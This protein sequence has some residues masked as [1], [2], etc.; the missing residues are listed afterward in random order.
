MKG[1][2]LLVSGIWAGV[3]PARLSGKPSPQDRLRFVTRVQAGMLLHAKLACSALSH[4]SQADS[5]L[6]GLQYAA[7]T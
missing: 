3:P 7:M 1:R 4:R 5:K 6:S 2:K